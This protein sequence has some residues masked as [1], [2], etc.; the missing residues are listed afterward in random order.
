MGERVPVSCY[1]RTLNEQ[2]RIGQ[3]IASLRD[4]V[5]EI[6]VVDSGSTDATVSIA[7]AEGA[8]VA[9]QAWLGNGR[10]K[11]FGEE[12]CNN[13]FL[14]DLDADEILT[15]ELAAEIRALFA[16]GL[17]PCPIYEIRIVTVPPVGNPW[18]HAA[19]AHR[20]KLYDRRVVRAPDHKAWDQFEVPKGA[21]VGRLSGPLLHHSFKD[22]AHLAEKFNRVSTVRAREAARR[23]PA[24]VAFRVLFA[25]P[26][27]FFKHL[28]LR[29]L[30][31]VGVYGVAAAGIAAYGRWLR[32]VKMYE[33]ILLDRE[34]SNRQGHRKND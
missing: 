33:Q 28:V 26:F 24:A 14:L 13:D 5:S 20:C 25:L 8:R 1:I 9:H 17:P 7:E 16:T 3:V 12:L 15:P 30:F 10:Q 27:Y 31:R 2:R 18:W 19:V 4:L 11:R 34:Q 22:L 21:K 29:G 32:D 23:S 6:W